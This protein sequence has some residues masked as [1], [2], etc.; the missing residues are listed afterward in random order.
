MVGHRGFHARSAG[1]GPANTGPHE[2]VATTEP[3]SICTHRGHVL[4]GRRGKR[5]GSEMVAAHPADSAWRRPLLCCFAPERGHTPGHDRELR[6]RARDG[7]GRDEWR[8]GAVDRGARRGACGRNAGRRL[9]ALSLCSKTPPTLNRHG[10][11][12]DDWRLGCHGQ[13]GLN[14]A[15]GAKEHTGGLPLPLLKNTDPVPFETRGVSTVC[16]S[17]VASR[18]PYMRTPGPFRARRGPRSRHWARNAAAKLQLWILHARRV[19]LDRLYLG[20]PDRNTIENARC[21]SYSSP[22]FRCGFRFTSTCASKRPQ[23]AGPCM[24]LLTKTGPPCISFRCKITVSLAQG[25]VHDAEADV[26]DPVFVRSTI[27]GR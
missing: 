21:A 19:G 25:A 20:H 5:L 8:R 17:G 15:F 2:A 18:A 23:D 24:V 11:S 10:G 16:Q 6:G 7:V 27:W 9:P 4:R 22:P 14:G 13:P 1:T 12:A 3:A 26:A